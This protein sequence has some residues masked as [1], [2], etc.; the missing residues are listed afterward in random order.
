MIN[1]YQRE[2][3][4]NAQKSRKNILKGVF[5]SLGLMLAL[6]LSVFIYYIGLEYNTPLR[7]PLILVNVISC[8][9]YSVVLYLIFSIKYKRV[10][11]YV[12]MLKDMQ[13][14]LKSEGVNTFVR[15]DS[16]LISKNG[17][18]FVS[19]VVLEWSEKKQEYFERNILFDVEKQLPQLKKGDVIKHVTHANILI[20][21][22]L[23]SNSIFE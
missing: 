15:T 13:V 16:S 6:N 7:T 10:N 11:C 17:V 4:L 20:S 21:Y 5:I 18:D 23:A 8:A 12:N 3:Y 22:E 9:I 2:D 1:V 19:L 14:G